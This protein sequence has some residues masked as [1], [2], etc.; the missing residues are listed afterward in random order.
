MDV[1]DFDVSPE[2]MTSALP[3][4]YQGR[5]SHHQKEGSTPLPIAIAWHI[6]IREVKIGLLRVWLLIISSPISHENNG[7]V[8]NLIELLY[9]EKLEEAMLRPQ[10]IFGKHF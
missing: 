1:D 6:L 8:G 4:L 5:L 9:E 2:Q 10:G 7:L 3:L